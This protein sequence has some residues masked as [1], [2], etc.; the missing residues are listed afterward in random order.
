[1]SIIDLTF[2]NRQY[3]FLWSLWVFG[4]CPGLLKILQYSGLIVYYCQGL[5]PERLVANICIRDGCDIREMLVDTLVDRTSQTKGFLIPNKEMSSFCRLQYKI[6]FPPCI[7]RLLSK[8]TSISHY[9]LRHGTSWS[10]KLQE[11]Y[12]RCSCWSCLLLVL[13]LAVRGFSLS[14]SVFP[15]PSKPTL[16]NS[17]SI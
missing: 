7:F 2:Q 4:S 17:N 10:R 11:T 3:H 1:M 9:S 6:S 16:S 5:K 13:F 12:C 15:S 8:R 14:T